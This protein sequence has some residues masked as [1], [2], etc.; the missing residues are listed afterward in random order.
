METSTRISKD[1]EPCS[2]LDTD[3]ENEN[4]PELLSDSWCYNP[5]CTIRQTGTLPHFTPPPWFT[6]LSAAWDTGRDPVKI[7]PI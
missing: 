3:L 2:L 6:E 4:W 5:V 1:P 7:T